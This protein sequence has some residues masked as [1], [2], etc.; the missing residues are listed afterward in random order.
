MR[1]ISLMTIPASLVLASSL[2]FGSG[3]LHAAIARAE[4]MQQNLHAKAEPGA[5]AK[6][7]RKAASSKPA[8]VKKDSTRLV[9][10]PEDSR[11]KHGSRETESQRSERLSRECKGAVNAGACA[12]YTR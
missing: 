7:T 6:K 4:V 10:F 1:N 12:G 3:T 9:A 2:I 11:N 8:K 5:P